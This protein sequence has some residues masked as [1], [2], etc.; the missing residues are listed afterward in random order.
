MRAQPEILP[1]PRSNDL[2]SQ[3]QPSL[4]SICHGTGLGRLEAADRAS[5]DRIQGLPN[6]ATVRSSPLCLPQ[7]QRTQLTLRQVE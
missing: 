5:T 7:T 3:P 1:S 4:G 6:G 2:T